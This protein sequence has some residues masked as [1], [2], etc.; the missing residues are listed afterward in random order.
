MDKKWICILLCIPLIFGFC[1]CWLLAQEETS[2]ETPLA[3]GDSAQEDFSLWGLIKASGILGIGGL[4]I[5]LSVVAM[6]LAI[7]HFVTLQRDKLVP[8]DLLQEIEDLFEEESYE[9]VMETCAAE[10][11]FLTN[12]IA[13]ALPRAE[14]GFESMMEAVNSIVEEESIKLQQKISWLQLIGA[15]APMLGL[16]GTVWGMIKA[17]SKIAMMEGAPKPKHLAGGIYQALVTTCMG[18]LVAIFALTCYFYFR[19]KVVR[20]SMEIAGVAEELLDRFRKPA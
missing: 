16:L 18:L 13:S 5:L 2:A 11:G 14:S 12:V 7:E 15:I 10:P 19:N 8:P 3:T 9:E 6:A 4:I 1:T 20:I 17:F